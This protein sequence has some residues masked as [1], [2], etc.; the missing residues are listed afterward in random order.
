[1]GFEGCKSQKLVQGTSGNS[2][3]FLILIDVIEQTLDIHS[4][5]TSAKCGTNER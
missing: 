5:S 4:P 1:M 3:S 2:V